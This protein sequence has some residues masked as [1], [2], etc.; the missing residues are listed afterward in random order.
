VTPTALLAG[1]ATAAV[2]ALGTLTAGAVGLLGVVVAQAV[3]AVAPPDLSRALRILLT[4]PRPS[5]GVKASR[6]EVDVPT[7]RPHLDALLR[8]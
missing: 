7:P 2:G 4:T 6:P 5:L 3:F 8:R 1:A